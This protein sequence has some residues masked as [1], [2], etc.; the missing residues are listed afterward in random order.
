MRDATVAA[1]A[2]RK[3]DD[4]GLTGSSISASA[5]YQHYEYAIEESFLNGTG[6]INES[7]RTLADTFN[8]GLTPGGG[9]QQDQRQNFLTASV[10][11]LVKP[12]QPVTLL[13]GV[14]WSR[15]W[16]KDQEASAAPQDLSP[17]G[18]VSARAGIIVSRCAGS[19][20]MVRTASPTSPTCG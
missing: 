10:Q 14:S 5:R 18:Q 16:I 4:L 11:T 15:P 20:S 8:H 13:G 9:Y 17:G 3:F 12:V 1:S 6:N 7:D 19:I 2:V